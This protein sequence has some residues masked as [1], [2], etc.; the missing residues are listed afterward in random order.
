[1]DSIHCIPCVNMYCSYRGRRVDLIERLNCTAAL[2]PT[3]LFGEFKPNLEL[4]K[5]DVRDSTLPM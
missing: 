2:G 3:S 4:L 1:M 5:L